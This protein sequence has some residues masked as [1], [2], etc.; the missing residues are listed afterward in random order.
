MNN[1]TKEKLLPL[2]EKYIYINDINEEGDDIEDLSLKTLLFSV[3]FRSYRFTDFN[4]MGFILKRV[5]HSI[6]F[7]AGNLHTNTIESLCHQIKLITKDF[8]VLSIEKLN[9]MLNSDENEINK[10]LDVWICYS[11]C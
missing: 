6:W 1:Q 5:N 9:F 10:Y 8:S 3:C 11:L 4:D 7:R 2:V